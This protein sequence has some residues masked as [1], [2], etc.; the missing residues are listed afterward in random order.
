MGTLMFITKQIEFCAAHRL[1][2]EDLSEEENRR[3]FG[4][5]ANPFGHGHNYVLEATFSGTPDKTTGMIV[6]FDSLSRLLE[7]LVFN[8]MDH[9]HLNHDVAFLKGELPTSENIVIV[10]WEKISQTLNGQ[11]FS[12]YRLKLSSSARNAVE[13]FGPEKREV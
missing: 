9:R 5:C 3:L 11:P 6:H 8:P 10:L 2:R 13:Y 12:L 1:F 7:E 4:K